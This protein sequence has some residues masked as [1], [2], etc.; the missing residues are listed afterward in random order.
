MSTLVF[1]RLDLFLNML[2]GESG[3]MIQELATNEELLA[4]IKTG[5]SY[6]DLLQW[7]NENY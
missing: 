4:M 1:R 7:I 6:E 3:V 2:S 5:S